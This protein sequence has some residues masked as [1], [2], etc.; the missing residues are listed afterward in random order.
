MPLVTKISPQKKPNRVNVY[1]DNKFGFGIDLDNLVIEGIKLNQELTEEQI[2][3]TLRKA[4]FQLTYE[5]L[6]RFAM[7]RPRSIREINDW[8]RRKQIHESMHEGL[9]EKLNH[10][11]LVGDEKFAR[12]WIDQR[13]T[14][15]P[16]SK[17]LL[18]LELLQKGVDRNTIEE[19]LMDEKTDEVAI[20]YQLAQKKKSLIEKLPDEAAKAKLIGFLARKGFDWETIDA[21][22]SKM[23]K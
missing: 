1:L 3:Q 22:L 15:K 16:R 18:K 11:E 4:E 8:F 10:L 9:L 14:F 17:K 20:A 5:K 7:T 2:E 13:N 23:V 21:V 12:W 19:I 6:L